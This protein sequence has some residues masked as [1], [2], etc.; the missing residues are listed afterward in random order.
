MEREMA[1]HG[2]TVMQANVSSPPHHN[3]QVTG[4]HHKQANWDVKIQNNCQRYD[5]IERSVS[6]S[7][8]TTIW[9]LSCLA[10]IIGVLAPESALIRHVHANDLLAL[11]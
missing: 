4:E 3:H 9:I 8:F 10:T 6:A 1:S 7:S 11:Q 5:K 2:D